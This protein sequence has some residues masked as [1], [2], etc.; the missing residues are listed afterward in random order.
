MKNKLFFL[1]C[2]SALLFSGCGGSSA[3]MEPE[4]YGMVDSTTLQVADSVEA[5]E[6]SVYS[7]T[8]DETQVETEA[9]VV[10][11]G[12]NYFTFHTDS[13]IYQNEQ[14]QDLLWETFTDPDFYSPDTQLFDWVNQVLD[15]ICRQERQLGQDLL[16]YAEEEQGQAGDSFYS[17]S[18]Y[19]TMG[20]GRHDTKV[21]SVLSLSSM[22]SGGAHP[23][24]VQTAVNL[25][26]KELRILTLEDVLEDGSDQSLLQMVLDSVQE[27]FAPVEEGLYPDYVEIVKNALT[28]GN[29]TSHWYFNETGLVIFFNQYELGPYAAGIIKLELPYDTLNGILR[30]EFMPEDYTGTVSGVQISKE[31]PQEEEIRSI[32]FGEGETLYIRVEGKAFHVQLS[33][34]FFAEGTPVG[35]AMLFSTNFLDDTVTIALQGDWFDSETIYGVEYRDEEDGSHVVYSTS[36]EVWA[37]ISE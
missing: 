24:T 34:V 27:K 4:T 33:E 3:P 35:E 7:T 21:A 23:S 12:M 31:A 1:F 18:H 10:V 28:Y 32:S 13:K 19:F 25:D 29:M 37:D 9:N 6:F 22:Y 15:G 5:K 8:A 17:F 26:M 14:G 16:D 11:D 36:A 20:V 2:C 30:Q